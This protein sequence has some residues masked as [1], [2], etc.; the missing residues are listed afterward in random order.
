[1]C[2]ATSAQE[3][4]RSVDFESVPRSLER[5]HDKWQRIYEGLL[6]WPSLHPDS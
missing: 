3:M 6:P 2:P 1:M 5:D 4:V